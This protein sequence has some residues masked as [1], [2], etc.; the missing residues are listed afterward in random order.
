MQTTNQSAT[1]CFQL[2]YVYNIPLLSYSPA[3]PDCDFEESMCD[4]VVH[5]GWVLTTRVEGI[6]TSGKV[7]F[8]VNRNV[9]AHFTTY[10][11]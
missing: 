9:V 10:S 2:Q 7:F 11:C 4:W 5:Q 3:S 6:E 1:V 8:S